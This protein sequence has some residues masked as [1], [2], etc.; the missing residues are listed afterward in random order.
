VAA[1]VLAIAAQ[2][3]LT[4]TEVAHLV[5]L[6]V[7]TTSRL[8]AALTASRLVERTAHGHHQLTLKDSRPTRG[9]GPLRA[10]I[11]AGRCHRG[12]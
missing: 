11:T 6:P 7:S 1:I 12:P 9:M 3:R 2:P 5:R 8:L 4:V 10:L